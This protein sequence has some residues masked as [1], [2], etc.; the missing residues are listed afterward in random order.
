MRRIATMIRKEFRQVFRDPPMI[1]IMSGDEGG[2][3]AGIAVAAICFVAYLPVLLLASG[4]LQTWITS[5]WT[6]AYQQFTRP[7]APASPSEVSPS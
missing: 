2:M 7:A 3:R 5:A 1:G 6:L 4:I